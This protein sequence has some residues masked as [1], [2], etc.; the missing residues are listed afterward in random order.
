MRI[1]VFG[2]DVSTLDPAALRLLRL[3]DLH[4]Q[5]PKPPSNR[6]TCSGS[7]DNICRVS[8]WEV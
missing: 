8:L 4:I 2:G 5:P 1:Y 3:A 6:M 7:Q